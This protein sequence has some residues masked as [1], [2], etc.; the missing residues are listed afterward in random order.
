MFFSLN[1]LYEV[2]KAGRALTEATENRMAR[3][4]FRVTEFEEIM[5]HLT[6]ALENN[7]KT[8]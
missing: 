2:N 7:S 5:N 1:K 8:I 6:P 4:G 3:E